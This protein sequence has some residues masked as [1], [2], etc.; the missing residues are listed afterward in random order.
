MYELVIIWNTGEKEIY[1]YTNRLEALMIKHGYEVAF[2]NQI[3]W[4]GIREVAG[5]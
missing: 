1:K 4:L 5:V 3:E 2:G